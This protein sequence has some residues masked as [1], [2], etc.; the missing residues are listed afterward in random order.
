MSLGVS[1]WRV[2]PVFPM[3]CI[4]KQP[5]GIRMQEKEEVPRKSAS[6]TMRIIQ[7]IKVPS[8]SSRCDLR[9]QCSHLESA[10]TGNQQCSAALELL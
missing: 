3:T 8:D 6:E 2:P 4:E 10:P 5:E 9:S 1:F 7:K